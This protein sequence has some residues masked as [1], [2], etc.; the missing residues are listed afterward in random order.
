MKTVLI[1]A[2]MVMTSSFANA[3]TLGP[4]DVGGLDP[5]L[6]SA[7]LQGNTSAEALWV[8]GVVGDSTVDWT[9]KIQNVSYSQ[10]VE[11][12]NVWAFDLLLEPDYFIVKNSNVVALFANVAS[13]NY[14][15]FD[16]SELP[17]GLNVPTDPWVISH[18]TSLDG[19]GDPCLDCGSVRSIPEP[20]PLMLLGIGLVGVGLVKKQ[21]RDRD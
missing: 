12:A 18:V 5:F 21:A 19:T 14:G 16:A 10:V 13:I 7:G 8:Q 6:E 17:A 20:E 4:D 11:D 1:L 3:Y 2:F 15:V 9:V